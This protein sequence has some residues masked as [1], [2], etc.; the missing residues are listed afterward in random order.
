MAITF[1]IPLIQKKERQLVNLTI[2]RVHGCGFIEGA[3]Q[4]PTEKNSAYVI[5]NF[6]NTRTVKMNAILRKGSNNF[7]ELMDS[8]FFLL[9]CTLPPWIY[10]PSI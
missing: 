2:I 9:K 8:I 6:S 1:R 4:G 5:L 3:R 10:F 7:L